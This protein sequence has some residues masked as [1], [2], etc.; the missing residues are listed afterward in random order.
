MDPYPY[1]SGFKSIPLR[2]GHRQVHCNP[3]YELLSF[4]FFS[5]FPSHTHI[6]DKKVTIIRHQI[7]SLLI[8]H[9]IAKCAMS[10]Y[11]I[12]SLIHPNEWDLKYFISN[13]LRVRVGYKWGPT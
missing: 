11:C 7:S 10:S 8:Y 9:L 2:L 6:I 4:I 1:P 3:H 5:F 13:N 12:R